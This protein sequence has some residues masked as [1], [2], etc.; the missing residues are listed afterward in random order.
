[1]V[2][3]LPASGLVLV[4][5]GG[6]HDLGPYLGLAS[7]MCGSLRARIRAIEDFRLVDVT[8]LLSLWRRG[9]GVIVGMGHL[10]QLGRGG[11]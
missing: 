10:V 2:A 6:S 7:S 8:W 5:L 3:H 4:V 9:C 1:M 11:P